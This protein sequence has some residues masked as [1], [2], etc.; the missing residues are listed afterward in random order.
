MAASDHGGQGLALAA[1][2][3]K[4]KG[5]GKSD[6]KDK[7]KGDGKKSGKKP[8]K[9]SEDPA[10]A[11]KRKT[12]FDEFL[13]RMGSDNKRICVW[14]QTGKCRKGA[15]CRYSHDEALKLKPDEHDIVKRE[16]GS[17]VSRARSSSRD[18]SSGGMP[19]CRFFNSPAGCH[20]TNCS[21]AHGA[22]A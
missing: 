1:S 19:V 3:G 16:I 7:G 18:K 4:G 9:G 10:A 11:D 6:K 20:R 8:Q 21:F 22:S 5:A 15:E 2:D 17:L 14:H 13:Q 12:K